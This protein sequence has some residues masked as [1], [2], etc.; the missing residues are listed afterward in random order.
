M[1]PPCLVEKIREAKYS[2]FFF[3]CVVSTAKEFRFTNIHCTPP[4]PSFILLNIMIREWSVPFMMHSWLFSLYPL[5]AT[6]CLLCHWG[7]GSETVLS[8][9]VSAY[10]VCEFKLASDSWSLG[11]K[12][13]MKLHLN[14]SKYPFCNILFCSYLTPRT[15]KGDERMAAQWALQ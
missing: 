11:R 2:F 3:P 15:P 10:S 8:R 1:K 6:F 5:F 7:W 12:Q 13:P 4:L 14:V 9:D